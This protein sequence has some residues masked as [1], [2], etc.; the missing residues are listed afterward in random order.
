[1]G[2]SLM[3]GLMGCFGTQYDGTYVIFYKLTENT[4][5]PDDDDIG[6]ERRGMITLYSTAEGTLVMGGAGALLT[7]TRDGK[8]FTLSDESGTNAAPAQ[9]GCDTDLSKTTTTYKGTFTDDG[10]FEGKLTTDAQRLRQSCGSADDI[11]EL[12][13]YAWDLDGMRIDVDSNR[14]LGDDANWGYFPS[15]SVY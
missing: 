7:G 3:L 12:E 13:S 5:Y 15:A 4:A 14:H 9:E 10:G 6:V 11:D 2:I 1:M 8:E